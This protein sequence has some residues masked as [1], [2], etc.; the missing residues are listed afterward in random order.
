MSNKTK[1][2]FPFFF[3][4]ATCL[5]YGIYRSFL[6]LLST[7]LLPQPHYNPDQKRYY[8]GVKVEI[9]KSSEG[10]YLITTDK[11]IYNTDN[12]QEVLDVLDSL[13]KETH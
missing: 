4:V 9:Y 10:F 3:F 8:M 1:N 6:F 13:F 2:N 7:D 11:N 12:Y 5:F